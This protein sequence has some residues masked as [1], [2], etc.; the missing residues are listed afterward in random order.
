MKIVIFTDAYWPR[1]NGVTVSIDSFSHALGRLGHEIMIICPFYPESPDLERI[2]LNQ[3]QIK[4]KPQGPV[5]IRVPSMPF[6]FSKED[7]LAKFSKW[8]WVSK[9]IDVFNPDIIHIQTEFFI[10]EFGFQYAKL[11]KLPA[12][13]T[14]HTLW[15]DYI[16]NYIPIVP[17]FLLR[18]IAR[19]VLR[20][21][22]RRADQII[23]PT[24]QIRDVVRKYKVKKP[25]Y[26]LPTGIDPEFFS[27][28]PSEIAQFRTALTE[29]HPQLNGKRILLFA[30]R[31]AKEK[32][33]D[34]LLKIAPG[35][36][37]KH[38]ELV[39]L[40]VG[41]GPDLYYYQEECERLGIGSQSIFTGY[42]ARE[43]LALIYGM[44]DIFVFPSLTETQGL[45]TIEAML[46]GTPVVAIG[47]M[48]TLTVMNGD[49]GGFMVQ[50]DPEE[51]TRR[52]FE[53]LEDG[54]L[55]RRKVAEAKNHAQG[56]TIHTMALKLEQLYSRFC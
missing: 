36:I 41:N 6:F 42:L 11:R 16:A 29:I 19:G 2:S 30:G 18:S 22:L 44:S 47:V 17:T 32:N 39:F 52:V 51:F 3:S 20:N 26:L 55:Y 43:N 8:F 4:E 7:R 27:H 1:V 34:F 21:I 35:I 14:F 28:S 10:A 15:E 53:L 38:P 45:V 24:T 5:I 31:I 37:Q 33:I 54:D 49:N 25:V 50:N 40:F 12:I 13:Y 23:V 56:W 46:S 9:Q 48:G